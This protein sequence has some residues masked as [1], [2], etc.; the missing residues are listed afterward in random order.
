MQRPGSTPWVAGIL[1]ASLLLR[2]I[3]V[4]QG[5]QYYFSDEE[6]YETSRLFAEQLLQ[7]KIT[8]AFSQF[9]ISPEHL[10]F[11][12]IG[13]LPALVEQFTRE[14][15]V[16]PALFFSLFSTLNL[17]ALYKISQRLGAS[18]TE[19][20]YVLILAA[21]SMSLLY[22]SRHLMPYDSA[23]TFG[24]FAVYAALTEKPNTK[25]SLACGTLGFACFITYNGSARAYPRKQ[26]LFF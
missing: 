4:L 21:L 25:T 14:S 18:K 23:M 12:I 19:S 9:F 15:L 20:L 17:L 26:P 11:K 13:I 22:Y 3:L 7:G 1:C 10:G 6:R 5:G 24:L 8:E 16:I 2:W